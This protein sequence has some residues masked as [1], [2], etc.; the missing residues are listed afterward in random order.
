MWV[1]SEP[2]P[3]GDVC[4]VDVVIISTDVDCTLDDVVPPPAAAAALSVN[5]RGP[6]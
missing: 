5:S 4:W 1:V 2:G 6:Y 3:G